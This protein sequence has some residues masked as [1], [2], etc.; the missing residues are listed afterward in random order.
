[1]ETWLSDGDTGIRSRSVA[2]DVRQLDLDQRV[3]V[4]LLT[5]TPTIATGVEQIRF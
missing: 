4:R 5:T 3:T 1:M 2:P